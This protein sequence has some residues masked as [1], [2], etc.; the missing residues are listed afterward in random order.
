MI[1]IVIVRKTRVEFSGIVEDL[2]GEVDILLAGDH[3]DEAF[4]VKPLWPGFERGCHG[5]GLEVDM[6]R[7]AA[8]EWTETREDDRE[9]AVARLAVT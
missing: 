7:I 2:E 4:G 5:V 8:G 3:G 1:R 6:V 9:V